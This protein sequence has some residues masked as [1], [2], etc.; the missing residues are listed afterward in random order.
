MDF[1]LEIGTDCGIQ[2]LE[3]I[4]HGLDESASEF[5]EKLIDLYLA[6]AAKD[7]AGE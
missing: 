1:L 3:H 7:Q 6:K 2:Y 5:H 4:I